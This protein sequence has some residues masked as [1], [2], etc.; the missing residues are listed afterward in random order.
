M[1]DRYQPQP[2]GP[3]LSAFKVALFLLLPNNLVWSWLLSK[4]QRLDLLEANKACNDE[5]PDYR[6][7][8]YQNGNSFESS[9]AR[10]NHVDGKWVLRFLETFN[11]RSVLECGP[12]SGFH[13]RMIVE[14]PSVQNYAGIDVNHSFIDYLEDKLS[15][16][17]VDTLAK[18]QLFLGDVKEI[19][20]EPVDAVIF[21]ASLHH[22]PDRTEIFAT[23]LKIVKPG[24]NIFC[25][26]PTH[27]F[28]R[29]LHV[30]RKVCLP[31]YLRD[32]VDGKTPL[33]THHFCTWL[34]FKDVESF[35]DGKLR[36]IDVDYDGYR[37]ALI[38]RI[39]A[40]LARMIGLGWPAWLR[41][42]FPIRLFSKRM[43]IVFSHVRPMTE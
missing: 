42:S 13:T 17:P 20:I 38:P 24:G 32:K 1:T 8:A 35:F 23:L 7:I 34:E 36:I 3:R 30:L 14:H 28:P 41:T 5:R 33:T 25:V 31:G 29:F 22:M 2:L 15:S 21:S 37:G 10:N 39:I 6:P 18:Y 27:Y 19:E 40:K 26:E 16:L 43:S 4:S 12:G 9:A 11:P